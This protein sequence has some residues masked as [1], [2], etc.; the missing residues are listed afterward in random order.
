MTDTNIHD[1]LDRRM[2]ADRFLNQAKQ[3]ASITANNNLEDTLQKALIPED[4][5]IVW[6]AKTLQNWKALV[7]T[8]VVSGVYIEV[9]YNG[10]KSEAYVDF[11]RKV[12]NSA[13]PVS[14]LIG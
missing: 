2:N 7:S 4:M 1:E 10:D 14:H 11:Y 5:Y 9:T 13:I 12:S 8:D 6:F 3:A